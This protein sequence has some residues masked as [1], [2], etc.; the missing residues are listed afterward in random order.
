MDNAFLV[1][2][3][4]SLADGDEQFQPLLGRQVLL[5]TVFGDGNP[6]DEFHDEVKA[7]HHSCFPRRVPWRCWDGPSWPKLG[8]RPQTVRSPARLSI[9]GLMIFNATRRLTGSV[10]SAI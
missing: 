5:V 8:V 10:C 2:V 7:V 3:L 9:P 1:G 6:V 4:D